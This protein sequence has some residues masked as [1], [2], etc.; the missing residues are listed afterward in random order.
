MAGEYGRIHGKFFRT[1]VSVEEV[2]REN[3]A[4][5]EQRFVTMNNG[6]DVDE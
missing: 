6:G 2:H 1:K 5:G 3:E 4:G